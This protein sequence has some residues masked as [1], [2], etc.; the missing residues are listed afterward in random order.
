MLTVAAVHGTACRRR[1]LGTLLAAC[2][3]LPAWAV[4][5]RPRADVVSVGGDI[6]EIVC[7]LGARERLAAV[8]S[9]STWPTELAVLPRVG[10]LRQLGAEGVLSL[11]ASLVL[12][13][14][15]AGPPVVLEQLRAA[16]MNVV[17]LPAGYGFD[18]L[19]HKVA[20]VGAALGMADAAAALNVRL[21]TAWGQAQAA[22]RVARQRAPR[23]L[24]LLA[25]GGSP[26]MAGE[27]TAAGTMLRLA[28]A[29]NALG[30]VRG[31]KPLGAE[32]LVAAAP[33][34]VLTTDEGLQA[35]GGREALLA[36][37]GMVLTPAGAAARV[38]SFDAMYLLG[39]GP[40]LPQAVGDLAAAL[41]G[42]RT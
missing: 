33:D 11:R 13:A 19:R 8:D 12:A 37:P 31:Y 23:V 9:T 4:V 34:L 2:T 30:G 41:G 25:H 28:G 1:L 17:T 7:A 21:E 42:L 35:I 24:F 15:Q 27:D 38:L 16:G 40:R 29:R 3:G 14:A 36:L 10:Y 20:M 26:Q 22:V 39:F 5:A 18:V 6:S 32:A